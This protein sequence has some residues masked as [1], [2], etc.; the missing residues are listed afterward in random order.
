M[1]AAAHMDIA[2]SLLEAVLTR[3][4][5]C[6]ELHRRESMIFAFLDEFIRSNMFSVGSADASCIL[7]VIAQQSAEQQRLQLQPKRF[8]SSKTACYNVKLR[9]HAHAHTTPAFE[10]Q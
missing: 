6:T 4:M 2:K 8:S 10:T 9:A 3:P 7:R 5:M 1:C